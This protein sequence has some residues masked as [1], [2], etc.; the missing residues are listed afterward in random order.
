MK[1]NIV[2]VEDLDI[3]KVEVW[4]MCKP[5]TYIKQDGKIVFHLIDKK[6]NKEVKSKPRREYILENRF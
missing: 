6:C 5:C 1:N 4:E 2:E 3:S